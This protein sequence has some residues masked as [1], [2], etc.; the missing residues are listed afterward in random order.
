METLKIFLSGVIN[1]RT[2]PIRAFIKQKVEESGWAYVWIF[3]RE[4]PHPRLKESFLTKIEKSDIFVQ[5]LWDDITGVVEEEFARAQ[6]CNIPILLFRATGDPPNERLK[7]FMSRVSS[8]VK[9]AEYSVEE[10]PTAV[11]HGITSHVIEVF[12][13]NA[14]RRTKRS[15]PEV[16]ANEEASSDGVNVR[17]FVQDAVSLASTVLPG[18]I[19]RATSFRDE[20][21][22][23]CRVAVLTKEGSPSFVEK[24]VVLAEFGGGYCVEWQSGNLHSV[25]VWRELSDWFGSEDVDGDN[26]HE[27][28]FA[29]GAHGTGS[30]AD[31]FHMYAP[32]QNRVFSVTLHETRDP[33]YREW[34]EPCKC[35]LDAGARVYWKAFEKRLRQTRMIIQIDTS[36]ESPD[37]LWYIDN[38]FLK[39]GYV[40]T[41]VV[42]GQPRFG[43]TV[44]SKHIDG[45]VLWYAFFKGPVIGYDRTRDQHFVIYGPETMYKW[46]TCFASNSEYLWFGTQGGE[47]F[48]YNKKTQILAPMQVGMAGASLGGV[49]SLDL[50]GSKLVI[51]GTTEVAVP[52]SF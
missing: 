11:L 46:A 9:W 22:G 3:E 2:R 1:E 43:A 49:S 23:R 40:K 52:W 51:D 37:V 34:V 27:I 50:K 28:F 29:E 47:V 17:E 48:Q 24:A 15:S 13:Q 21:D 6:A 33:Y 38:G 39:S 5:I 26:R 16:S 8:D 30:G 42:P 41:R 45:D 7:S 36:H 35:L 4:P 44:V 31:V 12:L 20:A 14:T 10:L 32:C 25:G 19:L 18:R